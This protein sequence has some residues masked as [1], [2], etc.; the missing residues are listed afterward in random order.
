MS[1]NP[2]ADELAQ[3]W[4]EDNYEI[5]KD[6]VVQKSVLCDDYTNYCKRIKRLLMASDVLARIVEKVF[7][8]SSIWQLDGNGNEKLFYAGFHVKADRTR[9]Y[10]CLQWLHCYFQPGGLES[11]FLV[12]DMFNLYKQHCGE[13]L[14]LPQFTGAVLKFFSNGTNLIYD[15]SPWQNNVFT[16]IIPRRQPLYLNT[17]A[18]D[19]SSV[20]N[21]LTS[22][23]SD[24]INRIMTDTAPRYL[25][26][27]QRSIYMPE[28]VHSMGQI[29]RMIEIN[30]E[31]AAGLPTNYEDQEW[32][33]NFQEGISCPDSNKISVDETRR[34]CELFLTESIEVDAL[35]CTCLRRDELYT[36]YSGYCDI[37]CALTLPL[38]EFD[39]TVIE[40]FRPSK[41]FFSD[42]IV[43][44]GVKITLQSD[45]ESKVEEMKFPQS[46]EVYKRGGEDEVLIIQWL[47]DNFVFVHD[48]CVLKEEIYGHYK[49][50]WPHYKLFKSQ[51]P[52]KMHDFDKVI[53]NCFNGI[54]VR[55]F[56]PLNEVK[57]YYSGM[58]AKSDGPCYPALSP[59]LL[60]QKCRQK[61]DRSPGARTSFP[62]PAQTS[63]PFPS[64]VASLAP[65]STYFPFAVDS[66]VQTNRSQPLFRSTCRLLEDVLSISRLLGSL[67]PPHTGERR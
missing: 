1:R 66:Q 48:F 8:G 30:K 3:N 4:I 7:P 31:F 59:N 35:C 63:S 16:R 22:I 56:G 51:S 5:F 24:M 52:L 6:G 37:T 9:I 28:R 34:I 10:N 27:T 53:L 21:I 49:N 47:K 26:E 45:I 41:M 11:Q 18:I 64:A 61:E 20:D 14:N 32:D 38:V 44:Y 2:F 19:K 42:C 60:V 15:A 58:R 33:E 57:D 65:V 23:Y 13:N 12:A 55:R 40:L 46:E 54:S 62:S 43:Y 50:Y 67:L 17:I 39:R 36:A 25:F 29:R